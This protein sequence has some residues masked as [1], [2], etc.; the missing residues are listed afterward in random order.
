[1]GH[2]PKGNMKRVQNINEVIRG[3]QRCLLTR[4]HLRHKSIYPNRAKSTGTGVLWCSYK[5][6]S[7]EEKIE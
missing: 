1:M 7:Q 2:K 3:F 4:S 6:V 5:I